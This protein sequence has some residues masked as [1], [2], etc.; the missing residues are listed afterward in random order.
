MEVVELEDSLNVFH[1][2]LK[3]ILLKFSR[4]GG[5]EMV[6][7]SRRFGEFLWRWSSF[8]FLSKLM[9]FGCRFTADWTVS[10]LA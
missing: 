7:W 2:A 3:E 10:F 4:E 5:D 6:R 8:Q 1:D 9:S